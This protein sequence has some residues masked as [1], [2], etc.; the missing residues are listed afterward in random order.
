MKAR[1][2]RENE[3]SGALKEREEKA[4]TGRN[5]SDDD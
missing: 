3:R 5:G 4:R 2:A 1:G